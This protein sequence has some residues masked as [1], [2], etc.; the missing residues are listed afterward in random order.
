MRAPHEIVTTQH[1]VLVLFDQR[2]A[3]SVPAKSHHPASVI[4]QTSATGRAPARGHRERLQGLSEALP[5]RLNAVLQLGLAGVRGVRPRWLPEVGVC[6]ARA[7][8]LIN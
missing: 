6:P 1:E 8:F 7:D 4:S 2:S 3:A 5:N